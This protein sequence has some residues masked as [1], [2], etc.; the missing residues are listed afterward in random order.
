LAK[1][2]V[3][4]FTIGVGTTSGSEIVAINEQ[5]QRELVRDERGEVVHSRL[6][7]TTLRTIA[8]TTHGR[9]HPLGALGEGLARVRLALDTIDFDSVKAPAR[10]MGVDRFHIPIAIVLVLLVSESLMGTRRWRTQ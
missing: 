6:D 5:G 2:G 9:Y 10:K 7:E 8:E 1:K 3:V 4:V